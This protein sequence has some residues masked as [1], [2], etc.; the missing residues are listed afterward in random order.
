MIHD[1]HCGGGVALVEQHTRER[2]VWE[3]VVRQLLCGKRELHARRFAFITGAMKLAQIEMRESFVSLPECDLRKIV[4]EILVSRADAR[5]F[6]QSFAH[7]IETRVVRKNS[8]RPF[9]RAVRIL[10][11]GEGQLSFGLFLQFDVCG[12]RLPLR[13]FLR[14]CKYRRSRR[15]P[16]SM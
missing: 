11:A 14:P 6:T 1:S 7:F 4:V 12:S 2:D 16:R 9:L 5:G 10:G 3:G 15:G 8:E 13:E